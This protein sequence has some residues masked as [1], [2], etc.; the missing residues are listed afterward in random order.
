MEPR[1]FLRVERRREMGVNPI[2]GNSYQKEYMI[3]RIEG[4]EVDDA[5]EFTKASTVEKLG[6]HSVVLIFQPWQ[7]E[8]V[9]G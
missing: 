9:Q 2:S 4:K 8:F 7:C 1:A 6:Q 5:F 3:V